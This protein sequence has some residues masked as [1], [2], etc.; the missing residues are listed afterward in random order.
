MPNCLRKI[1]ALLIGEYPIN[2][3]NGVSISVAYNK[4]RR[5]L[6]GTVKERSP[7]DIVHFNCPETG[8]IIIA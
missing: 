3:N 4:G 1:L 2:V 7:R 8:I 6:Q 5:F